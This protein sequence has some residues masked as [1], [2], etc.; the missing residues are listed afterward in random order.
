MSRRPRALLLDALGTL[1]MLEPPAPRLVAELAERCGIAVTPAQAGRA[2]GVE[3]AYYRAH[4]GEGRDRT[5]L[6][7]LR[8]RCAEVL[9]LALPPSPQVF[10]VEHDRLTGALLAALSFRAY[11]DAAPALAAA[12]KRG[13]RLVVASNWDVSLHEILG[14][15]GLATQLDA[16][17]TSAQAGA[18]K[19]ESAVFAAALAR[20]GC[21]AEEAVHVGD[22]VGED[23]AGAQ[24]VGIR[25]V[26]IARDGRPGPA[27]VDT[28]ASL[29]ELADVI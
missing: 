20:A 7:E 8:G 13:L 1:V 17:V 5:S 2:L 21:G 16:I 4:M 28:I 11:P 29:A 10:A 26:L 23:V 15:V 22:G 3:I 14:R 25:P 19:P 12:R 27:G 24:A 9:R 6:L 18:P